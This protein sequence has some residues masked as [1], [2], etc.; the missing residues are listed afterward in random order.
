MGGGAGN[1]GRSKP[2]AARPVEYVVGFE[3]TVEAHDLPPFLSHL[4]FVTRYHC[5]SGA[6]F[7]GPLVLVDPEEVC[8]LRK[9][10]FGATDTRLF[11]VDP[12]PRLFTSFPSSLPLKWSLCIFQTSSGTASPTAEGWRSQ[13][14]VGKDAVLEARMRNWKSSLF[15]YEEC[16]S[17]WNVVLLAF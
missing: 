6:G 9:G 5:V 17:G 11:S 14:S 15:L 2:C 16:K 10:L 13:R 12:L 3:V 4:L 7:L 8:F 1:V